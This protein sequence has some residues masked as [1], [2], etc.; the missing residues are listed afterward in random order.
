MNK[1]EADTMKAHK[2]IISEL[3]LLDPDTQEYQLGISN[4]LLKHPKLAGIS[5]ASAELLI[6][7]KDSRVVN[8]AINA[9]AAEIQRRSDVDAPGY[10]IKYARVT[11]NQVRRILHAERLKE[12]PKH[13]TQKSKNAEIVFECPKCNE[14]VSVKRITRDKVVAFRATETIDD[15]I[16]SRSRECGVSRSFFVEKL[17]KLEKRFGSSILIPQ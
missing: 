13:K 14:E 1:V 9:I 8:A 2:E 10:R 5:Y 15:A 11:E 7:E 12:D 16:D 17:L 4:F 6:A 3:Y